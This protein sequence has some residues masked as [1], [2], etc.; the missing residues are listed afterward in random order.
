M[1]YLVHAL[2]GMDIV[3]FF[4]WL[5]LEHLKNGTLIKLLP[6]YNTAL[7]KTPHHVTAIYP[8]T[9][10]VYLKVRQIIDDFSEMF[11]S[12]FYWELS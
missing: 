2:K 7:K 11:G 3:L 5:I 1:D 8:S 10:H 9:R 6:N 4:D 12:P